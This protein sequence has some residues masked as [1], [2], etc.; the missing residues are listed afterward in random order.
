MRIN[1]FPLYR[2]KPELGTAL[3]TKGHALLLKTL[4]GIFGRLHRRG[5]VVYSSTSTRFDEISASAARDVPQ[6][7]RKRRIRALPTPSPKYANLQGTET[8]SKQLR[9]PSSKG[10]RYHYCVQTAVPNAAMVRG[11]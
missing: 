9:T 10:T 4:W 3:Q 6:L 1:L 5:A 7:Y 11:V 2:T 8:K